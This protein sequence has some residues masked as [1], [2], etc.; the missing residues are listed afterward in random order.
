MTTKN[1]ERQIA[2]LEKDLRYSKELQEELQ[3][4]VN[5]MEENERK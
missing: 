3:K 5:D 4:K 1:L 2:G